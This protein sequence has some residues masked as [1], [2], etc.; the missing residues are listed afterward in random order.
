M[1]NI[2]TIFSTVMIVLIVLGFAI[3][4]L[5]GWKKS[6]VR[7]GILLVAVIFALLITPALTS[8]FIKN[9]VDGFT[10]SIFSN[11]IDF[12][13]IISDF[14]VELNLGDILADGSVTNELIISVINVVVNIALFLIVFIVIELV[15][16]LVYGIV[17][18]IIKIKTRHEEKETTPKDGKFWGLRVVGGLVGFV[19]SLII[20]FAVMTP[21]Y[22]MINI[23]DGFLEDSKTKQTASASELET[24]SASVIE[25]RLCGSLYYTEDEKIGKVETYIEKYAD[26]KK[27]YNSSFLGKFSNITGM[28]KLGGVAFERLTTVKNGKLTLNLTDEFVQI[29]KTYNLYKDVFVK[30]EFNLK[31]ND[32][33]DKLV[34]LYDEAVK[35][36]VIKEYVVEIIP[37]LSDKWING[38]KF[39]GISNPVQNSDWNDVVKSA[40]V[41]FKVD[42]INRISNNLKALANA[43]KV[44]NNNDVINQI[45]SG[46]KVE[47]ILLENNKFIKE[48]IIVLTSTIELRENISIILNESFEVIYKEIIGEE[49]DFGEN[50]LTNEQIAW[51]NQT[52]GWTKEADN[53][54]NSVTEIF[55]VYEITKTDSSSEALLDKLENIGASIDYARDSL[56]ISKPY[57]IFVTDFIKYKTNLKQDI[58]DELILNIET[59]WEDEDVKFAK[60]FKTIQKSAEVAKDI[61]NN[62]GNANLDNLSGTLKDIADDDATKG[63]IADILKKDMIDEMVGEDNQDTAGVLTDMLETFVTSDKVDSSTIDDDIVAGNQILNIV[64]NVKN[65]GGDLNLGETE[66]EKKQSA[67]KIVADLSGSEG[68]MELITNSGSEESSALTNFTKN[69]SDDDK[70]TLAESI[71]DAKISTEKKDALKALFGIA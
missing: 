47:D 17:L 50:V 67:D 71:K 48:E 45:N 36:E 38:E 2:I 5:R 31:N 37:K 20:C 44:A 18:L 22:G 70:T 30:T 3:G 24:A 8:N 39:I 57:K 32:D 33:I 62:S 42:N 66:A 43:L 13:K 60:V 41:V 64:D 61:S 25:S 35:S 6:L 55:K 23:C 9:H 63:I 26:L 4:M 68:M 11:E 7:T 46:K 10:V 28:S 1:E 59:K 21:V 12:E 54:Q 19:G 15:S 56:L 53:I 69:V 52:N 27:E 40:L 65:N 16:L 34:A 51:L 58:K 14:S 29:I 49:K